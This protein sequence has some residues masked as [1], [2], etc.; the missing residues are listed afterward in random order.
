MIRYG[1]C[2]EAI[3]HVVD[4]DAAL[5]HFAT[6]RVSVDAFHVPHDQSLSCCPPCFRSSA[7]QF[8][9]GPRRD[10]C[11]RCL[12]RSLEDAGEV[13][14]ANAALSDS[15]ARPYEPPPKPADARG[16]PTPR[17]PTPTPAAAPRAGRNRTGSRGP[18]PR[19]V[20]P[21]LNA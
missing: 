19:R 2:G 10:V 7:G 6:A 18:E 16:A 11:G 15:G 20:T 13:A 4:Q 5:R 12:R 21:C 9:E 8:V 14:A 17:G 3:Y 1:A